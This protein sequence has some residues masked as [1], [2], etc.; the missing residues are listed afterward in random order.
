MK[1]SRVQLKISKSLHMKH[2]EG[3][4]LIE[5]ISVMV[6]MGVIFSVVIKKFDLL[7]DNASLTALTYGI[8]ELNTRETVAWSKIKLSD[9]GYANDAEVYNAVDK[10]IG[11]GY[12]WNPAVD[13][14]GGGL[15]FKSQSIDLNRVASM[16]TSPGAWK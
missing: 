9:V 7:S 13:I 10:N 11:P 16:P 4:T 8:R 12:S 6:I 5:L 14:S 3:F 1:L 2:Q 15:H